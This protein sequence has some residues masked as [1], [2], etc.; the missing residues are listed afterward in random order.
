MTEADLQAIHL[1]PGEGDVVT[2]PLGGPLTFKLRGEQTNGLLAAFE[3]VAGQGEGPPLHVHRNEDEILYV[4]EG[5][6]RIKLGDDLMSAPAGSFTYIPRG[7]AHTWQSVGATPARLLVVF[8][9]GAFVS[10]FERFAHEP[11]GSSAEQQFRA[12]GGEAGMDVVGPPLA[13]SHPL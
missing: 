1:S 3:S 12:L 5:T 11:A 7:T 4:L 10:F 13:R 6:L 2:N 8:T 9:P